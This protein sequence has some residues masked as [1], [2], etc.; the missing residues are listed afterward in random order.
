MLVLLINILSVPTAAQQVMQVKD[1]TLFLKGSKY[2]GYKSSSKKSK[3][4]KKYKS[5]SGGG[6]GASLGLALGL[7]S[8]VGGCGI[9]V[10]VCMK[11]GIMSP[12][13]LLV[14][15]HNETP[16]ESKPNLNSFHSDEGFNKGSDDNFRRVTD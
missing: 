1:D 10:F 2:K 12:Q 13:P 9:C 3:K 8:L 15:E 16:R 6:K 14:A 5:G 11:C 4:S 7:I